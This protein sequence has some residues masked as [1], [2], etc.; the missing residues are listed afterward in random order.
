MVEQSRPSGDWG[1]NSGR[2]ASPA[3]GGGSAQQPLK[4]FNGA[5]PQQ[6]QW[7][8]S[9][10]SNPQWGGGNAAQRGGQQSRFGQPNQQIR[11]ALRSAAASANPQVPAGQ[12]EVPS[13]PKAK[14]EK[15]KKEKSQKEAKQAPLAQWPVAAQSLVAGVI[16]ALALYLFT[17]LKSLMWGR[18]DWFGIGFWV[19]LGLFTGLGLIFVI[20]R[21]LSNTSGP[22]LTATLLAVVWLSIYYLRLDNRPWMLGI[23]ILLAGVVFPIALMCLGVFEDLKTTNLGN[24]GAK[25][26]E[27]VVP[28]AVFGLF[29]LFYY[30]ATGQQSGGVDIAVPWGPYKSMMDFNAADGMSLDE[31][32]A[33]SA[34]SK[35]LGFIGVLTK[36]PVAPIVAYFITIGVYVAVNNRRSAV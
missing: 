35:V 20:I 18:P 10:P 24:A 29:V 28:I 7:G 9:R 14:K 34:I 6:P 8:G 23:L 21:W 16:A 13:Q 19:D 31:Y 25:V 33:L 17:F 2:P 12:Q 11:E 26:L 1:A 32:Q 30:M 3:W 5:V 36:L 22:Y 4:R 15:V 27:I